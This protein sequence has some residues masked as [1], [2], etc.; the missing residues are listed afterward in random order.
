MLLCFPA[1]LSGREAGFSEARGW[2]PTWLG[3]GPTEACAALS[4]SA[5]VRA[6]P[7]EQ[8]SLSAQQHHPQHHVPAHA[9]QPGPSGG[10]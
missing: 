6:D 3:R 5:P 9:P 7:R 2:L 4:C 1:D 10:R 8:L